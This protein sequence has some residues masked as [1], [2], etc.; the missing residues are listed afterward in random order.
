MQTT[1]TLTSVC[2][3]K[4]TVDIKQVLLHGAGNTLMICKMPLKAMQAAS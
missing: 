2:R 4:F 1:T 3:I